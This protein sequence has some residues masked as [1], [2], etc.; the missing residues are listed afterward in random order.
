[1]EKVKNYTEENRE[2]SNLIKRS[3]HWRGYKKGVLNYLAKFT[4][5]QQCWSL[6]FFLQLYLKKTPAQVFFYDFC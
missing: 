2:Q 5:K 3:N 6:F 1:M 4:G